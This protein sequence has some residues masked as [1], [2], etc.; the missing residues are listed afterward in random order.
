VKSADIVTIGAFG[1]QEQTF[2]ASL[3]EAQVAVF[4]DV[5]RRRGVRG[6][7]Y[8][9]VNSLR[10]Q[11]AIARLDIEY[12]HRLN[13]APSNAVR[14]VQARV[15][16]RSGTA[17]RQR[18]QLGGDFVVAYAAEVLATFDADEFLREARSAS[19]PVCLFC[20]ERDPEACHRSLLADRLRSVGAT[21]K[22]L[23]P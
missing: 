18:T 20:V 8:A 13:L 7:E 5:R 10:L 12:Q 4:C 23:T 2:V 11:Q 3:V 14:G 22:H 1:W 17:K 6:A 19:G 9:W 15:D 16:A 21:V